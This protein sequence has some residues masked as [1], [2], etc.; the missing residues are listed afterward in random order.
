MK[1]PRQAK[2][3][4]F[5]RILAAVVL[6]LSFAA[7]SSSSVRVAAG[8]SCGWQTGCRELPV[9]CVVKET[10]KEIPCSPAEVKEEIGKEDGDIWVCIDP[11]T[12]QIVSC[13]WQ[14]GF[15]D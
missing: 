14:T 12:G 2:K 15:A 8:Q 3:F 5:R 1:T 11:A 6:A 9:V 13:G 4:V 10:G 7:S